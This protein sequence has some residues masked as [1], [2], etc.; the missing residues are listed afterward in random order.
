MPN[1]G[2]E[3]AA[4][5][6]KRL[7]GTENMNYQSQKEKNLLDRLKLGL[8]LFKEPFLIGFP[9]FNYRIKEIFFK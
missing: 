2:R 6:W 8:E 3:E 9:Y 4:R 7:F 5:E 1:V